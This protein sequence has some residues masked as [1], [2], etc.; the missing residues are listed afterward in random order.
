MP[1]RRPLPAAAL[2]DWDGTVVDTIP[3]IYRANVVVLREV[4][5]TLTRDWYRTRYTPDWRRSYTELGIPEHQ[6]DAVG[7]R[8]A[9]EMAKGRPRALPWARPAIRRLRWHGVRVG[10]VT[11]SPRAVVE[12][13]LSRLNL[14][15]V[16]EVARY[17]DDVERG[18]PHPDA[19]LAALDE[20]GV[21]PRDTVYVGDTPVDLAMAS[22]AGAPFV[23][24]GRTTD[25]DVF[26]AHGVHHVWPGVGRWVED[27]L[28]TS[29]ARNGTRNRSDRPASARRTGR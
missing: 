23:A 1:T 26:R 25:P 20:L 22:A 17:S 19:L 4:G 3:M 9:E 2:F 6:W 5:I 24:V 27:L 28:G 11:A 12:H 7:A 14:D 8:W 16:F 18:K 10:L 15:G 29:T 13:N 21:Q